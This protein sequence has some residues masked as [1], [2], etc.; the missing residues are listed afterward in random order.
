MKNEPIIPHD[1]AARVI[2]DAL[3]LRV[4]RGKRHSF[5]ALSDA[6]GIPTRTLESYVQGATPGLSGL[7][8]I[9]SVLGPSFTSDVLGVCGQSA[10]EGSDDAPEHLRVLAALGH[11][12]KQIAEAVE[13][14][15]VDHR[16]AAQLRPTAQALMEVLE[17]LARGENVEPIDRKAG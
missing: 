10:R 16:E 2:E 12:T 15:H 3:R 14:G 7:L 4:G 1:L 13:D 5:A 11:L 6:T 8:S 17:P 9:C